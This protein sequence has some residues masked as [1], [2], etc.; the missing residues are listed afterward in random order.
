MDNSV[1]MPWILL[2]NQT[3]ICKSSCCCKLKFTGFGRRVEIEK[4]PP[5]EEVER[6]GFKGRCSSSCRSSNEA[7][8]SGGAALKYNHNDFEGNEKFVK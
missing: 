2:Q 4:F 3:K 6:K 8:I 5:M 1:S 7:K